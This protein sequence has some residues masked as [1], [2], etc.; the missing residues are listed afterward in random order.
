MPNMLNRFEPG[1]R[2]GVAVALTHFLMQWGEEDASPVK[3]VSNRAGNGRELYE[4]VGCIVCHG[5]NPGTHRDEADPPQPGLVSIDHVP[6]KHSRESLAAFLFNPLTVRAGGRM[7]DMKLTADEAD[8]IAGYLAS[9]KSSS[10]DEFKVEETLARQGRRYFEE[11]NCAACHRMVGIAPEQPMIRLGRDSTT[12]GCLSPSV[13]NVPS[14]S[15]STMQRDAIVAV[16]SGGDQ[17]VKLDP[18][19]LTMTR[20]NCIGCH[21]RGEYGGVNAAHEVYFQT[22]QPELGLEA[23]IPPDLTNVGARLKPEVIHK[24]LIDGESYRPYVRTRMPQFGEHN[25]NSLPDQL[26][27]QDEMEPVVF[28][29]IQREDERTVREAGHRLVGDT[30]LN[31]VIC[32][33]VNGLESPGFKGI[34]LMAAYERL[35]PSWFYRYL[36]NPNSYRPGIIMPAFWPDGKAVIEDVLGGSPDAQIKAIWYYLSLGTSAPVPSGM[37]REGSKLFIDDWVRVYRGRSSV[38]GYRGIAVG[39]PGGLNYAF[40]A[41]NGALAALWKGNF[42]SVGWSGQGSGNF[43]PLSR[44]ILLER[45]TAFYHLSSDAEPWP[46]RPVTT[47]ENPINPDPLYPTNRGY[48]FRGYVLDQQNVPT[49]LY[50]VGNVAIEDR[51]SVIRENQR[52]ALVRTFHFDSE[53]ET[54]IA[55]RALAGPLAELTPTSGRS[56]NLDVRFDECDTLIRSLKNDSNQKELILKIPTPKG[57]S[58]FTLTYEW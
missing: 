22:S 6:D 13:H 34:D 21:K 52:V 54:V 16:L 45:D 17:E 32:H 20:F 8:A 5:P 24:V 36:V 30:G 23:R 25:L 3:S 33:N 53:Q 55:F 51:S 2:K 26:L 40:D 57:H 19:K 49:F 38:A 12:G 29:E 44:P 39:F 50:S 27:D 18:V 1:T 42:V 48:Q 11:L 41:Q 10:L 46:R 4:T 47:K 58:T 7:P 43:N 56:G 37:K 9:D 35:R 31:C 14:Y 28:E 15:L